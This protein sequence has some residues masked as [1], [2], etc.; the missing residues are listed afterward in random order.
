MRRRRLAVGVGVV[1]VVA[2]G[3]AWRLTTSPA[4]GAGDDPFARVRPGMTV[5][6]VTAAFGYPPSG[7]IAEAGVWQWVRGRGD[8]LV[9]VQF[10]PADRVYRKSR[11][12]PRSPRERLRDVWRAVS[13][14]AAALP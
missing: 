6:E 9:T 10:D 5:G 2:A 7:G 4:A 14:K 11:R 8:E 1:A 13:A 12:F 3:A